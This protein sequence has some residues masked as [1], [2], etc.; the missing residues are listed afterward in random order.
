MI[1]STRKPKVLLVSFGGTI[2]MERDPHTGRS[3]PS[4]SASD[5]L[6]Q[7]SLAE[8]VE[9]RCVDASVALRIIRQPAD[10]LG[11]A[12]FLQ[13]HMQDDIDGVV[14]THGTDALEEVAYFIDEM[15]LPRLP[16]V[17]TGAMRPGWAVDYDGVR[18]LENAIR[19]AS[20]AAA[21]YGVLV[22]LH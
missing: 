11:V 22:T 18:N 21:E 17:F 19:I 14:V 1:D 4:R 3:I 13:H 8:H 10:L 5:L 15:F 12:R 2:S 16:I 6:T 7:T 20:V 9:V